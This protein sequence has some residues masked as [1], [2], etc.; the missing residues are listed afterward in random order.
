MDYFKHSK[1]SLDFN[2]HAMGDCFALT[3]SM[4]YEAAYSVWNYN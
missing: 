2:S 3:L 4:N 1:A